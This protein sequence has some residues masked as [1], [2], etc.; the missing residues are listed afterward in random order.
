MDRNPVLGIDQLRAADGA[1]RADGGTDPVGLFEARAQ[2]TRSL[3]AAK[4][5]LARAESGGTDP[6]LAATL[7]AHKQNLLAVFRQLKDTAPPS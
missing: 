7:A 6:A 2:V 4:A 5:F 3:K 1:E